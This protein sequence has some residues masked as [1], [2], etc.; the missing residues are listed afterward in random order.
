MFENGGKVHYYFAHEEYQKSVL[1]AFEFFG[2]SASDYDLVIANNGNMPRMSVNNALISAQTCHDDGVPFLWLSTYDGHGAISGWSA[3]DKEIFYAAH[4]RH[5]PIH[6]MVQ[7]M[8]AF[9][10]SEAE[11]EYADYIATDHH[12]CLPGPPNE[13]SKLMLKLVWASQIEQGKV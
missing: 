5:V 4:A 3:E 13:L 8:T 9:T 1:A 2:T 11:G 12:Y 6:R 10:R 7:S